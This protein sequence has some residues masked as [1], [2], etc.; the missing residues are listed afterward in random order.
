MPFYFANVDKFGNVNLANVGPELLTL[1]RHDWV[2]YD[3]NDAA[4]PSPYWPSR[5][6][7]RTMC[8]NHLV[9]IP[10]P[11]PEGVRLFPALF[12]PDGEN[13]FPPGSP[14]IG[15]LLFQ[16]DTRSVDSCF[17]KCSDVSGGNWQLEFTLASTHVLRPAQFSEWGQDSYPGF[18]NLQRVQSGNRIKLIYYD[19]PLIGSVPVGSLPPIRCAVIGSGFTG[20]KFN[21]PRLLALFD[22][23]TVTPCDQELESPWLWGC[24]SGQQVISTEWGQEIGYG[25]GGTTARMICADENG[26]EVNIDRV[27]V[28]TNGVGSVLR[29]YVREICLSEIPKTGTGTEIR[30]SFRVR[31]FAPRFWT[32]AFP[33]NVVSFQGIG[34][35]NW[36]PP[37][38]FPFDEW[39]FD[40]FVKPQQD[41]GGLF[42]L[43]VFEGRGSFA[44][45]AAGSIAS[46][47]QFDFTVSDTL[48]PFDDPPNNFLQYRKVEFNGL[49]LPIFPQGRVLAERMKIEITGW[50]DGAPYSGSNPDDFEN[51]NLCAADN[52]TGLVFAYPALEIERTGITISPVS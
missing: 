11:L 47:G 36:D 15:D 14:P 46:N 22:Q 17:L 8:L 5:N 20:D 48:I 42:L 13:P 12:A 52:Q 51:F 2:Y 34:I 23:A 45:N 37:L 39:H 43:R 33:L 30:Q 26:N 19:G 24:T 16:Q 28:P 41:I 40:C 7:C 27:I 25:P 10:T 32:S 50:P 4:L 18:L 44:G 21:S 6:D 38:P 3:P 35:G 1:I 9:H 31:R 29:I 49:T